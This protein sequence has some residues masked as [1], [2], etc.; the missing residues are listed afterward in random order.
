MIRIGIWRPEW[1]PRYQSWK[2]GWR[3]LEKY[4]GSKIPDSELRRFLCVWLRAERGMRAGEIAAAVGLHEVTVRAG[5]RDFIARGAAAFGA[6][7]RGGRRNQHMAQEEEEEFLAG[8]LGAAADASVLV[9]GEIKAALEERLG[10]EVH[11]TTV[12]R[13]PNRHGWRKVI[14]RPR[15]SKRGLRGGSSKGLG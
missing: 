9:A 3:I 2:I 8:F 5:Q 11:E 14:P 13:M 12:Y 4:R 10:R 15:P 1:P 6:A 7:K